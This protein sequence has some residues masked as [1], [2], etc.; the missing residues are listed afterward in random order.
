[1][2]IRW[3]SFNK[4]EIYLPVR[5]I[6]NLSV[7]V[8]WWRLNLE[9]SDFSSE[10]SPNV[11][12]IKYHLHIPDRTEEIIEKGVP[13]DICRDSFS[14]PLPKWPFWRELHCCTI[15]GKVSPKLNPEVSRLAQCL[16]CLPIW[17]RCHYWTMMGIQWV[18]H[19]QS[20][21]SD[22]VTTNTNNTSTI[23]NCS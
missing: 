9:F 2:R 12:I 3:D 11:H 16:P 19:S 1:M 21:T 5:F 17:R 8:P 14:S 15:V 10:T 4:K 23:T 13:E 6:V 7:I 20:V 18:S 22:V